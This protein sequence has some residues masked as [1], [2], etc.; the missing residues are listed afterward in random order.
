MSY[1]SKK[2]IQLMQD[3]LACIFD[4]V[5]FKFIFKFKFTLYFKQR[6]SK[7]LYFCFTFLKNLFKVKYYGSIKNDNF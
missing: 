5:K 4:K 1:Y 7:S 3:Y 2:Q 6:Q